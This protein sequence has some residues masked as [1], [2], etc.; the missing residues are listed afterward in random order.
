LVSGAE[1]ISRLGGGGHGPVGGGD[2]EEAGARD[3][4]IFFLDIYI[5]IVYKDKHDESGV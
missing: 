5:L 2:G 1:K 4:I 3:C